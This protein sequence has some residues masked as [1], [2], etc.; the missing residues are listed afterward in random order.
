MHSTYLHVTIN[1]FALH[2]VA[3]LMEGVPVGTFHEIYADSWSVILVST[4]FAIN[5]RE[6]F[7]QTLQIACR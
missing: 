4:Q 6:L 7:E 5:D 1:H 2:V 3:V